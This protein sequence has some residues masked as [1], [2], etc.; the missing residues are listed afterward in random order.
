MSSCPL[1]PR[2][3]SN[4]VCSNLFFAMTCR[5][6]GFERSADASGRPWNGFCCGFCHSLNVGRLKGQFPAPQEPHSLAFQE[7]SLSRR[8]A[9]QE[10]G[11]RSTC[12]NLFVFDCKMDMILSN[13]SHVSY[14]FS[15]YWFP[16]RRKRLVGWVLPVGRVLPLRPFPLHSVGSLLLKPFRR[17]LLLLFRRRLFWRSLC[18]VVVCNSVNR[19]TFIGRSGRLRHC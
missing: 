3:C 14:K 11:N 1:Y 6:C 18:E 12:S 19:V 5:G 2:H 8:R 9:L 4:Q 7:A 10:K 17:C 16:F 15:R 13:Q